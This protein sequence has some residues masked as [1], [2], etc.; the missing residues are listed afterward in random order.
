MDANDF[1]YLLYGY[2]SLKLSIFF[3][4]YDREFEIR[5]NN[6]IQK[7]WKKLQQDSTSK[8]LASASNSFLNNLPWILLNTLMQSENYTYSKKISILLEKYI[9]QQSPDGSWYVIKNG[10]KETTWITA[11]IVVDLNLAQT[12]F[13]KYRNDII[14]KK[15][16][17]M[18]MLMNIILG[19]LCFFSII[20]YTWGCLVGNNKW[21]EYIWHLIIWLSI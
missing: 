8:E 20:A 19:L 2:M 6:F 12:R 10:Q 14:Y 9:D 15:Q 4:K 16:Y 7:K 1:A 18:V 17:Q 3:R 21:Y 5:I 13:I 11:E